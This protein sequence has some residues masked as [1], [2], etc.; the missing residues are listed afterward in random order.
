MVTGRTPHADLHWAQLLS[1]LIAGDLSLAWPP[2][3][4]PA[5]RKLGQACMSHNPAHRPS[6]IV[7]AKVGPGF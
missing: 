6:T 5:I 4:H 2:D 3:T 1:G 7:L